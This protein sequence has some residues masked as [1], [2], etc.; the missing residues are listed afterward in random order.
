VLG[1]DVG[2]LSEV[3]SQLEEIPGLRKSTP[4]RLPCSYGR[5]TKSL[6]VLLIEDNKDVADCLAEMID[7]AGFEAQ[8]PTTDRLGWH[9]PGGQLRR[10]S[11]AISDCPGKSMAMPWPALAGGSPRC[12]KLV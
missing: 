6:R 3:W 9:S 1:D 8:V 11:S 4:E 10:S 12:R 2:A 5:L 7:L